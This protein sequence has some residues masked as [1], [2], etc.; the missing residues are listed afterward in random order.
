[1]CD[2]YRL[3]ERADK[4]KAA[5]I[6][7]DRIIA[8]APPASPNQKPITS[9]YFTSPKPS[10]RPRETQKISRN[11]NVTIIAERKEKRNEL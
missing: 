3:R 6:Q 11:G 10:H 7:K 8:D 4:D 2:L 1:M 5:P 9:M